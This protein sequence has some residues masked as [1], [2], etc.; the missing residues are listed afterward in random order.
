MDCRA[1]VGQA[2]ST[3]V[4]EWNF[5]RRPS[6]RHVEFGEN[7]LYQIVMFTSSAFIEVLHFYATIFEYRLLR[8]WF[9]PHVLLPLTRTLQYCII[10]RQVYFYYSLKI[11]LPYTRYG[12]DRNSLCGYFLFFEDSIEEPNIFTFF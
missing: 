11:R 6:L 9:F 1:Q 8:F 12:L 7:S 10:L 3:N 4:V 5:K 2:D